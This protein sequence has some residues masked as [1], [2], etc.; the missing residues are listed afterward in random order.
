MKTDGG[1][2]EIV[3]SLLSND[4]ETGNAGNT[5]PLSQMWYLIPTDAKS[6]F[7]TFRIEHYTSSGSVLR[8]VSKS[9][10]LLQ[11]T[12]VLL[13]KES[14]DN[15]DSDLQNTWHLNPYVP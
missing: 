14:D 12:T 2:Q 8:M 13:A 1:S 11:K 10:D 9:A 15:Y 3:W 4:P 7:N 6:D 5:P